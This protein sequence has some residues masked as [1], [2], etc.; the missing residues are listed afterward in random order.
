MP[1]DSEQEKQIVYDRRAVNKLDEGIKILYNVLLMAVLAVLS[2]SVVETNSTA[3][4]I[5]ELQGKVGVTNVHLEYV[6]KSV[7]DL[8]S[9]ADVDELK[10]LVKDLDTRVTALEGWVSLEHK[11]SKPTKLK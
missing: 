6:R 5:I 9:K 10:S 8:P 3:K 11:G 4:Q 2:W 1:E 7:S